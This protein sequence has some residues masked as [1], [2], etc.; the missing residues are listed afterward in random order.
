MHDRNNLPLILSPKHI[1]EITGLGWNNVYSLFSRSDFPSVK[2]GKC[3][4]I[5]RD[6]FFG[7]FEKNAG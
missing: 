2:I 6:A 7:W 1:K 3:L 4:R 5:G